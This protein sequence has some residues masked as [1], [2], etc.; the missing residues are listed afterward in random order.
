VTTGNG[1][2]EIGWMKCS[3]KVPSSI[4]QCPAA[5]SLSTMATMSDESAFWP[6]AAPTIPKAKDFQMLWA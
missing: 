4:A 5:L 2:K 3:V 6:Q 1:N